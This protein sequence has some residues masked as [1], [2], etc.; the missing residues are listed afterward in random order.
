MHQL[1]TVFLNVNDQ[2]PEGNGKCDLYMFCWG[3]GS[4]MAKIWSSSKPHASCLLLLLTVGLMIARFHLVPSCC[5]W[6]F[7]VSEAMTSS[8]RPPLFKGQK[9]LISQGS[10]CRLHR[11]P[12]VLFLVKMALLEV[13]TAFKNEV[14]TDRALQYIEGGAAPSLDLQ[15]A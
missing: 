2:C 8:H 3:S 1:V 4:P 9:L 6:R 14:C 12:R 7:G 15:K 11:S 13:T 10:S 5:P